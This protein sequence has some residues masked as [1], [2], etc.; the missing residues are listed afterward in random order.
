[1][2]GLEKLLCENYIYHRPHLTSL[3][4]WIRALF[5][6]SRIFNQM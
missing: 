3:F 4:E 1:M 6:K 5:T 2:E